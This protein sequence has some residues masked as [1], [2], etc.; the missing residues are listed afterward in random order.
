MN[1]AKMLAM[2]HYL[3]LGAGVQS[4]TVA[5]MSDHGELPP[6]DGGIFA[7]TGAEPQAV[8]DWLDWLE[9]Q[10]NFPIY[11]VKHKNLETEDVER[12]TSKTSGHNYLRSSVPLWVQR[13]PKMGGGLRRKCTRDF[14]I[15][16]LMRKVKVGRAPM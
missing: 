4:S 5:F 9:S 7:D 10:V 6:L 8:Y 16:P 13:G 15:R 1:W 11:R 14:K 12:C 2:K 3:S